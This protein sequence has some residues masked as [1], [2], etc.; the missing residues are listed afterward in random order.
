MGASFKVCS[1]VDMFHHARRKISF[2]MGGYA[3]MFQHENWMVS[4]MVVDVL[5]CKV[6]DIL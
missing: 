4:F 3:D 1:Y 6:D 5:S 2:E